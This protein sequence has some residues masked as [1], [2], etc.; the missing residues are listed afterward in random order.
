[1]TVTFVAVTL[2]N[3]MCPADLGIMCQGVLRLPDFSS[4]DE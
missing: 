4:N 3:I 2:C 1:M